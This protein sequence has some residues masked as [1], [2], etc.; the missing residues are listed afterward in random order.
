MIQSNQPEQSS[1][2]YGLSHFSYG[3]KILIEHK[4]LQRESAWVQVRFPKSKKQRIRN[5][6]RKRDKNFGWVEQPKFMSKDDALY[7]DTKTFNQLFNQWAKR[8]LPK[9]N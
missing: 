7:C 4:V 1:P 8:S 3:G 2:H 9:F 6:W 5:K